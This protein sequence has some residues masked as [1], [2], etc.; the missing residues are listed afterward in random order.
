MPSALESLVKVLKLERDN[1]YKNNSVEGGLSAYVQRWQRDAHQ[2]AGHREHQHFLVDDVA[3]V[4]EA[5]DTLDALEGRHKAIGYALD[6]L[7]MRIR[8]PRAGFVPRFNWQTVPPPPAH[9]PKPQPATPNPSL[10]I[11]P[12]PSQSETSDALAPDLKVSNKRKK[13][14][15]KK[16]KVDALMVEVS[17]NKTDPA[18][19]RKKSKNKEYAF[20]RDLEDG[21]DGFF[22]EAN[23]DEYR[24]AFDDLD[25]DSVFISTESDL[26]APIRLE[27]P[28]RIR[29]HYDTK[30]ATH[31]LRLIREPVT[32]I[33]GVGSKLGEILARIN[34]HTI[35][36]LI[37][38]LPYRYDDYTQMPTLAQLQP[39]QKV[40]V[41][42]TV[43]QS[44]VR[45]GAQGRQDFAFTLDDGTWSMQVMFFSQRYLQQ[46]IADGM[47]VVLSGKV[48][49]YRDRLQMTNPEWQPL[50]EEVLD[51]PSILPIYGLTKGLNPK[52]FRK[53]IQDTL[54]RYAE[55]LPEVVP[56]DVIERTDLAD[57]VWTLKQ[58]HAP[59]GWDHLH[60]AQRRFVFNELLLLQLAI[61]ANRREWQSIQATPLEVAD[62]DLDAFITSAFPYQ[63]TGAQRRAI[64]DIRADVAKNIPMNRLI[65]GDVGSGK[66]AVAM[67]A[68]VLSFANDKQT[69]I[70]APTSILAEQHYQ[71][72]STVLENLPSTPK[73][74]VAL[75]TGSLSKTEREQVYAGLA[76]GSIDVV[77]GTHALI[78]GGISFADL[79]LAVIDEQHRFG[80][81][82]RG[83][84][85]GKGHNPHLLFMTA[86]PIPRTLAM[87]LYADLD[88]T[89]MNE[90]PVGRTPVKTTIKQAVD[91]ESVY[92]RIRAEVAQGRQAFIVHPLVEA[93][94][95]VDA[96]S[97]VEAYEE[98][99]LVFHRSR[100]GLLHGKMRADE[101]DHIMHAFA[102]GAIDVLVTTSVAE[103]GVN[104]PNATII[105]IE[106]ANR[107]GLSQLHQFRGRVGRGRYPGECYL[108]PDKVTPESVQR[109]RALEETTDGFVL[110]EMD[111][112]MR[113][114]GDLL[115]VRQS[116]SNTLQLQDQ[117]NHE[118]VELAQREAQTL[119]IVDPDLMLE[120]HH[121]LRQYVQLQ[122]DRR[123]DVS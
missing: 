86:T 58:L 123:S 95:S 96:K 84:L 20:G 48:S 2:Q 63:L 14:R 32:S 47:Q 27:R 29:R 17:P 118:L 70:M 18:R 19:T 87:T 5:Y 35:E 55:N 61:M 23:F 67:V 117:V 36:D 91:R 92:E 44:H 53:L 22:S 34:I 122:R 28:P 1:S 62:S 103:V 31:A 85:R 26:P 116:G 3:Q 105:M 110:A 93:S 104:V 106:G 54:A 71:S 7:M 13:V 8:E 41:V 89:V 79:G 57:W 9:K 111:W 74:K 112:Q 60:H 109:L 66:T 119:Y 21:N 6:R 39:D 12:E 99:H 77:I 30:Q 83:A 56:S 120:E 94:E 33:R 4:L 78:Q 80:V 107:F 82:Q 16:E 88:L 43:R 52:R 90:M 108:F 49:I 42:G 68:T 113:G 46:K 101:K 59:E 72:F 51:S 121:H 50:E 25:D 102:S 45:A 37:T 81:Q 11:T 73:P 76:D 15:Q 64:Q 40:T 114:A 24:E 65:Q 97:A 115:S 98:L 69:A 75:L 10:A 100:V 38:Y